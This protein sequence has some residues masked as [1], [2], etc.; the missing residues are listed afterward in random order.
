MRSMPVGELEGFDRFVGGK[1]SRWVQQ[2]AKEG[3]LIYRPS[4]PRRPNFC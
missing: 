2:V 1:G 3:N 4:F